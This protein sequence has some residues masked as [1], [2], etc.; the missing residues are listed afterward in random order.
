[1]RNRSAKQ[2][3][4]VAMIPVFILFGAFFYY[5]FCKNIYYIFTDFNYLNTPAFVGLK[6]ITD[7]LYDN[8]AHR[9]ILNTLLITLCSVPLT[10]CLALL[11]AVLVDKAKHWKGF[12][13]AAFFSTYLVSAVVAAIIFKCWF[14]EQLGI[15]NVVLKKIGIGA[16]PWLTETRWAIVAIV[17]LTVWMKTGYYFVVFL[18]GISNIDTQ[19]YEAAKIDGAGTFKRFLKITLP[20]LKPVSILVLIMATIGGLKM[21]SEVVVL[22]NGGPYRTT[23]TAL[24]Y[25]FEQGFDNR[26]VGYGSMISMVLFLIILI[27]T[28]IQ[29]KTQKIFEEVET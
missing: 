27:V 28:L 10:T 2:F 23:Q 3:V 5:P 21:Y 12:M 9:A 22:T 16:I 20:Q 29:M 4:V 11:L 8:E 7:F 25:M 6:N 15:V 24:M 13:R 19:L 14:N 18:A 17:I 1:M 26:N